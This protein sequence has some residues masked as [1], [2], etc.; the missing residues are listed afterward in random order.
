M[1][2]PTGGLPLQQCPSRWQCLLQERRL[3]VGAGLG[4]GVGLGEGA[5]EHWD[6]AAVAELPTP[7]RTRLPDNSHTWTAFAV[8][9]FFHDSPGPNSAQLSVPP[10]SQPFPDLAKCTATLRSF[11]RYDTKR[12]P[13][14]CSLPLWPPFS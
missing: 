12:W 5:F 11:R 9:G 2:E 3:N 13:P 1:F 14:L 10:L 4:L 8:L 6:L 7:T